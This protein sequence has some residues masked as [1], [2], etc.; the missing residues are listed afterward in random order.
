MMRTYY[1]IT[2]AR[3]LHMQLSSLEGFQKA[4]NNFLLYSCGSFG[5]V[6]YMIFPDPQYNIVEVI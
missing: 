2:F 4:F 5:A 3:I 6:K 1:I